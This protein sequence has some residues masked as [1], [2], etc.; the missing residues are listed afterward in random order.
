MGEYLRRLRLDF[1]ARE[2]AN[3]ET[4]LG[5]IA[6]AAGFADQSHLTKTFKAYFGL[7]PSEYRKLFGKG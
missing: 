2:I 4:L 3:T 1:A 6:I 7:K 5:E